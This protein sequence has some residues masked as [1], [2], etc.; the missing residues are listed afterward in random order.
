MHELIQN[1]ILSKWKHYLKEKA[2]RRVALSK[3][4]RSDT[5]WKKILRDWREF[6]RLLFKGRFHHLDYN[7]EESARKCIITLFRELNIS[8][9]E[10][11]CQ[12]RSIFD[13][14]NQS[15]KNKFFQDEKSLLSKCPY[16]AID[17]YNKDYKKLFLTDDFCSRMF[18]FVFQN[19]WGEYCSQVKE[20][21][22]EQI[23]K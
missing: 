9:D 11:C 14:L 20:R 2:E 15:Q 1:E 16:E 23:R 18:Y 17:K 4:P 7:D 5:I 12:Y 6:Y 8:L 13:F 19:F 22:R 21:Y 3:V 10:S